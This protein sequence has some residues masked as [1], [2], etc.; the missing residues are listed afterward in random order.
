MGFRVLT[1]MFAHESNSF[2][3]L[4]TTMENYRDYVL[5]FDAAIPAAIQGSML[6]LCGVEN[7]AREYGWD[8][9]H[10]L[11]AWATP[12]GPLSR[13]TWDV[14]AGH[15]L[16]AAAAQPHLDGVLLALHGAMAT[17]DFD[18]AEGELLAQLRERIGLEVP[19]AITLDLHANVSD[20]MVAHCNIISAYRTYPHIDQI[21][22]A[23]RAAAMLER[24][25]R[26]EVKP[27]CAIARRP[28]LCG[29]DDGR[30]TCDNP[31]TEVLRDAQALESAADGALL[32]SVQ[33]GFSPGDSL[34]S[35]PSVAVMCDGD[36]RRAQAIA[37]DFMEHAWDTRHFDSNHYLDVDTAMQHV[38]NLELKDS[39]DAGPVVIADFSDNPGAGAYGDSTFLLQALIDAQIPGAALATIC[40]PQAALELVAAGVG[41]QV[42]IS[43]GGKIEAKF[44][45]PLALEG[46]VIT[47][48]DGSYVAMG[49]RWR[50]VTQR[51][52]PTAVLRVN[53][54]D[55]VVASKRVQCTEL[56]TFS[57]AGINPLTRPVLVVK[58]MQHFRAAFEPVAREVLVVDAGALATRDLQRLPYQRVRRPVYP[59]DLD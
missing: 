39:V 42:E 44:G 37:E 25:M 45:P 21:A 43:L 13:Q 12:S 52:G 4:P 46:E 48:T 57:H 54:V 41:A 32:I 36:S 10:T 31:M 38:R 17:E 34:Q 26:G 8:L 14:C 33:A 27:V 55:I 50:G 15:I 58:S 40:D 20:R 28:M 11:A 1:G 5:A 2:S 51:L 29:F 24:T 3:R 35:G 22:T 49:P 53:G 59:L 30:T 6:E 47:I 19:V 23:E 56:E 16:E 9:V 7:A 18:D